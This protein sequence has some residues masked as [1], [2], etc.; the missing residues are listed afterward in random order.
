MFGI[1]ADG[2]IEGIK[3]KGSNPILEAEAQRIIE[4][5]PKMEPAKQDGKPADVIFSIPIT[6]QL[7]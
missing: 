4:R 3:S 5:L 6:F 7:K 1:N 2:G